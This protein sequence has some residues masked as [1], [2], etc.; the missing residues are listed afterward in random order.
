MQA[1]VVYDV[2]RRRLLQPLMGVRHAHLHPL[3]A[4]RAGSESL[5]LHY[6][7][8]GACGPAC[9]GI[10]GAVRAVHAAGLWI[11]NILSAVGLDEAG[12][13]VLSGVGSAWDLA[14]PFAGHPAASTHDLRIP[15]RQA[16]DVRDLAELPVAVT[17]CAGV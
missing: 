16:A 14:D 3:T 15:W 9:D 12:R 2:S 7:E 5:S 6:G 4:V 17:H 13:W 10:A 11:G 8:A 1:T